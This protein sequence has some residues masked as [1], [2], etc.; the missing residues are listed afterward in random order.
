MINKTGVEIYINA[1]AFIHLALFSNNLRCQLF[2]KR[3]KPEFL[4]KSFF[5]RQLFNEGFENYC[6]GI[7]L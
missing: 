4:L 6:T 2:N 5:Y 7:G 1:D 3:I